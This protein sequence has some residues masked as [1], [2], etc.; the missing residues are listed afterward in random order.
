MRFSNFRVSTRLALGFGLVVLG[1]LLLAATGWY[2]IQRQ[3]EVTAVAIDRDM[4]FA[5]SVARMRAAVQMMRRY[6]KEMLLNVGNAEGLQEARRR[7]GENRGEIDELLATTHINATSDEERE[8]LDQLASML[9]NYDGG[10]EIVYA[11]IN[12][13]TLATPDQAHKKTE[14]FNDVIRQTETVM[15]NL[16]A[17]ANTRIESVKPTLAGIQREVILVLLIVAAAVLATAIVISVLT[18]RSIAIPVAMA[19]RVAESLARG[20]LAVKVDPRSKDEI[21]RLMFA[22]RDTVRQLATIVGRIKGASDTVATASREIAQANTDLSSRTERQA[23]ALEE[24]SS[25]MEEMTATVSQ[26]AQNA[27]KA[28]ELAARA[29]SVATKGGQVVRAA[30]GTMNGITESSRKIADITSVIDGIAFQTNILAL[31]AAVEAARAGE[32]GRG[33]AVV[34]SEV[35]NLAQRSAAAAKEIKELINESVSKVDAGSR[36]VND[37]GRTM[38]EIVDSV[39]KVS[40]LIS[41][42]TAASREQAQ[43]IAQVSETVTQLEKVTQQNAAMV[44]EASAAAGSLEDQSKALGDAVSAFRLSE[45]APGA[46]ARKAPAERREAQAVAPVLPHGD[47]G[48]IRATEAQKRLEAAKAALK[49][50]E[51]K[52]GKPPGSGELEEEWREI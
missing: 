35:R 11:L 10:I 13:G 1:A 43:G 15:D 3:S 4:E 28:N 42:I 44:E 5:R 49:A 18:S 48:R 23:S 32:Q 47:A 22:L 45:D 17:G 26:N 41:E 29:S 36:Q 24:T 25:S 19:V 51:P 12:Q 27:E 20:D 50:P 34:A 39:S 31:N 9:Q 46:G 7:H 30:V 38:D 33:F 37:A 6:E 40:S 14:E 21:G 2:G 16:Y 52:R 8:R